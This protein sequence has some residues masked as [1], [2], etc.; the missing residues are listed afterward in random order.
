MEKLS[1]MILEDKETRKKFI[2]HFYAG[3]PIGQLSDDD[4]DKTCNL[5]FFKK[6]I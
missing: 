5:L 1:Q 3:G 6:L 4:L 2:Y